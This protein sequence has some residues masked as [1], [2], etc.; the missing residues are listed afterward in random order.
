MKKSSWKWP[1]SK[2]REKAADSDSSSPFLHYR[3]DTKYGSS[4]APCFDDMWNLIGFHHCALSVEHRNRPNMFTYAANEGVRI[5]VVT[6]WADEAL[7][8]YNL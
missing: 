2:A 1:F 4:G 6:E 7:A 8:S 3:A 5:N